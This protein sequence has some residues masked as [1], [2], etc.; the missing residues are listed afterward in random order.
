[1]KYIK[2][3]GSI[4]QNKKW[5]LFLLKGLNKQDWINWALSWCKWEHIIFRSEIV[6][7]VSIRISLEKIAVYFWSTCC[8]TTLY[9]L[10]TKKINQEKLKAY[11][12]HLPQ[13]ARQMS[14]GREKGKKW[15]NTY[16]K[17]FFENGFYLIHFSCG[18][19]P[20]H[21]TKF[22][23]KFRSQKSKNKQICSGT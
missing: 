23:L 16:L 10:N 18:L 22:K 21:H 1:M 19:V 5:I 2:R 11:K 15:E 14:K 7:L 20:Y 9:M 12:I 13:T 17:R 4:K 8:L 6:N 3:I